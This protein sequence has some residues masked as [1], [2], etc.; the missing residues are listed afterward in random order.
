M[1]AVEKPNYAIKIVWVKSKKSR[2]LNSCK[3]IYIQFIIYSIQR[4]LF[5]LF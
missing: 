4:V 2:F 3:Y 5:F 1:A